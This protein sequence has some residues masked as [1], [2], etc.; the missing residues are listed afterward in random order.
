MNGERTVV[1]CEIDV[2]RIV[3][4]YFDVRKNVQLKLVLSIM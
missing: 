1:R 2:D 4:T 3:S